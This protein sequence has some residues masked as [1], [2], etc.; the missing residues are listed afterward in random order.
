MTE[1]FNDG[2]ESGDF[3]AWTGTSVVG[4]GSTNDVIDTNPHTGTYCSEHYVGAGNGLKAYAQKS[5]AAQT[6]AYARAY[7]KFED[8]P[9]GTNDVWHFHSL[10]GDSDSSILLRATVAHSTLDGGGGEER[11]GIQYRD[12]A[13]YT[14]DRSYTGSLPEADTWYCVEIKAVVD[15]SVGEARMWVDG[16]EIYTKTGLTNNGVADSMDSTRVGESYSSGD[17]AH[18]IYADAVV[19]ADAY[20]GPEAEGGQQ[21]FTLINM[22]GY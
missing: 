22:M 19:V 13:G 3:S 11:W 8:I 9:T 14:A 2:F 16:V 15:G 7:I 10:Y 20:I 6:T 17:D 18:T 12:G 5:F 4:T 21:L 1:L